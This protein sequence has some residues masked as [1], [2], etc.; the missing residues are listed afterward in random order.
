KIKNNLIALIDKLRGNTEESQTVKSL[1]EMVNNCNLQDMFHD[2]LLVATTNYYSNAVAQLLEGGLDV[3]LQKVKEMIDREDVVATKHYIQCKQDVISFAEK[4]LMVETMDYLLMTK[5]S[6]LKGF[7]SNKNSEMINLFIALSTRVKKEEDMQKA[8]IEVLTTLV[9]DFCGE[10]DEQVMM[11]KLFDMYEYLTFISKSSPVMDHISKTAY[12]K[13][14]NMFDSKVSV[15]LVKFCD[16]VLRKG[17]INKNV[18]VQIIQLFKFL[19][20]KDMFE[21]HYQLMLS[22]RLLYKGYDLDSERLMLSELRDECGTSY[23]SK[24]EEMLKD[25]EGGKG[26]HAE[27]NKVM[28]EKGINGEFG[29]VVITGTSWPTCPLIT[30][31]NSPR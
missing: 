17:T 21:Q 13:S 5:K 30:F 22:K 23:T 24:L 4:E 28:K 27:L 10:K 14:I 2:A 3:F 8:L 29:M 31:R 9:K 7:I 15:A 16:R 26:W 19:P 11:K 12:E 20:G 25:V 18:G 6:Q 1:V